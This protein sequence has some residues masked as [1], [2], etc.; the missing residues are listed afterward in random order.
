MD[1]PSRNNLIGDG[2]FEQLN[3]VRNAPFLCDVLLSR[4]EILMHIVF[5]PHECFVCSNICIKAV[6]A[7]WPLQKQ[8]DYFL[9][10]GG[11]S[12]KYL[13][14]DRRAESVLHCQRYAPSPL[15]FH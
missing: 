11:E 3:V 2:A 14:L 7:F 10:S 15:V 6:I 12:T 9:L 5:S 1:Q 8:T 4:Y 13:L